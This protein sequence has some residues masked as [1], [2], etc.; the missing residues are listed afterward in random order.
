MPFQTDASGAWRP[1]FTQYNLGEAFAA[2][3]W[4][5]GPGG[6]R[7]APA[8]RPVLPLEAVLAEMKA[9]GCTHVEF[10]DTE[11][12]PADAPQIMAAVRNTGLQVSMC[13]A[14]LFK[15]GPEFANGNFGSPVA[16]TRAESVRRTKEYIRTGIEVFGASVYVYWNSS[17]GYGG[18]LQVNYR[19]TF[20]YT[21]DGLNAVVEWMLGEYG[22]ERALP[23]A[24]E[25]KPNEPVG[26]GVPADCGETL[27]VISLMDPRY[28]PFVGTNLET[29]HALMAGKRYAAELGMAAAAGKVFYVHLNGGTGLKFDED[30]AFGDNDFGVAV[31]TLYT[32]GE[33]GYSGVVAVDVQPLNTDTPRQQA[34]SIARSI[35]NFH[36]AQEVCRRIDS[37]KLNALRA[38]ANRAE[39]S[40]Y[41]AAVCSGVS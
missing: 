2:G 22:P 15:R 14:N 20:R 28:Q 4:N 31:E 16:A 6:G 13:T 27:A 40:D 26:W 30:L 3:V 23:I 7:F 11:A 18:P 37:A 8:M 34:A 5:V 29:C 35:R 25:P 1:A 19:D 17:N 38:E 36:R 33:I 9:A 24:I 32:L 21:A 41:F 10:H 39:I 12:E